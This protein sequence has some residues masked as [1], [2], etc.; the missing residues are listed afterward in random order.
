MS[1][2]RRRCRFGDQNDVCRESLREE[3]SEQVAMRTRPGGM[4]ALGV[5]S[6]IWSSGS[7]DTTPTGS[8]GGAESGG[9]VNGVC[10]VP[11]ED[12]GG[13][14]SN[15]D[16]TDGCE[17]QTDTDIQNCGG[18]TVLYQLPNP[19]V[20]RAGGNCAIS[21][22]ED[23]YQDCISEEPGCETN[24]QT[25]ITHTRLPSRTWN[26][27]VVR[28]FR[29]RGCS[30]SSATASRRSVQSCHESP[31]WLECS[32][33]RSYSLTLEVMHATPAARSAKP[34]RPSCRERERRLRLGGA[35][36]SNSPSI[37][38]AF[39][40]RASR[41]HPMASPLPTLACRALSACEREH[42]HR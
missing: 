35:A 24:T 26:D 29:S 16:E 17:T 4:L 9:S 10:G 37:P 8:D 3:S 25:S 40:I 21:E 19:T 2:R 6:G 33:R 28:G 38:T 30:T 12:P 27:D 42:Q 20:H 13:A 23:P 5:A 1:S 32:P 39:S 14:D 34:T 7:E 18:C 36:T 15:S 31:P 22:R 11:C 41:L